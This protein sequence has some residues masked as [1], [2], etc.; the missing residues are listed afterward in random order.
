V[1]TGWGYHTCQTVD[2]W[3]TT[4]NDNQKGKTR[5]A[6]LPLRSQRRACELLMSK[7]LNL[8]FNQ[9]HQS[10]SIVTYSL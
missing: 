8:D 9:Q 10:P 1:L 6:T 7:G 3:G 4:L 2:E 5:C